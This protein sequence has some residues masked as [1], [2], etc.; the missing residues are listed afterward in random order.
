MINQ[1]IHQHSKEM[2]LS[3]MSSS[4]GGS[5]AKENTQKMKSYLQQIAEELKNSSDV[6]GIIESIDDKQK[7]LAVFYA[8]SVEKIYDL[9]PVITYYLATLCINDSAIVPNDKL[10]ARA[11]RVLSIF[12]NLEFFARITNLCLSPAF[13]NYKGKLNNVKPFF[14]FIIMSDTFLVWDLQ[15]S[16]PK[17]SSLKRLTEENAFV[18][19]RAFSK[20]DIIYEGGLAH[21]VLFTVIDKYI[22]K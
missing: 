17:L 21:K 18:Y 19:Q 7:A 5:V 2:I 16:Y 20:E 4:M 3:H 1:L 8:M 15:D 11:M 12:G 14:D 22:I 13:G 10:D 9:A 6:K